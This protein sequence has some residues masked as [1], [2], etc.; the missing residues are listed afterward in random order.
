MPWGTSSAHNAQG[1]ASCLYAKQ[2][3][4]QASCANPFLMAYSRTFCPEST[5]PDIV[6]IHTLQKQ[7]GYMVVGTEQKENTEVLFLCS[8]SYLNAGSP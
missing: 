4:F 2:F 8:H 6:N 7:M 5:P 3:K 1:S